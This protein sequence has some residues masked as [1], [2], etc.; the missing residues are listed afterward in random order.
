MVRLF[1]CQPTHSAACFV[2]LQNASEDD[3]DG[4]DGCGDGDGVAYHES[5]F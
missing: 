4:D 2:R 5:S 1:E 3:G